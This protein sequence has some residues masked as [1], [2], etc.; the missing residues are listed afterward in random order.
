MLSEFRSLPLVGLPNPD[1]FFSEKDLNSKEFNLQVRPELEDN[2]CGINPPLQEDSQ[3][4]EVQE[5]KQE[6]EK[7]AAEEKDSCK[8]QDSQKN[9]QVQEQKQEEDSSCKLLVPTLKIQL[10]GEGENRTEEEEEDN[11][12]GFKT[13]T[14]AD[15]KIPLVLQRPP[16]PP[17]KP[18][19]LPSAKR[20]SSSRRRALLDLS[21]EIESLFPPALR[22]DLGARMKK[23]RQG[24]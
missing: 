6:E 2:C 14:S 22:S 18:K 8:L 7:A 9:E 11:S 4:N 24:N 13:P 15:H 21:N 23:A 16:A 10:P 12:D 1:M 20:K 3:K 19:A 5:P 17:R